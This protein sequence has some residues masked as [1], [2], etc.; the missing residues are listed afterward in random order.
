MGE[1]SDKIGGNLAAFDAVESKLDA[2]L[3]DMGFPGVQETRD[4]DGNTL[5]MPAFMKL[6]SHQ[7]LVERHAQMEAALIA[8]SDP[9]DRCPWG[10]MALDTL[11][12]DGDADGIA[13]VLRFG[14][15][16]TDYGWH[17]A[18]VAVINNDIPTLKSSDQ[19]VVDAIGDTPFLLACRLG[20]IDVLP[21]VSRPACLHA[22]TMIAA[23]CG[24]VDVVGW[25][26]AQGAS[27]DRADPD[28]ATPLLRAVE[29]G[30]FET[31]A[32]LLENGASLDVTVDLMMPRD[33]GD[34]AAGQLQSMIDMMMTQV[35]DM[36]PGAAG[37]Q[38]STIYDAAFDPA[39][40]R[41]LV[42][43]GADPAKFDSD[44]LPAAL[45]IDRPTNR[46]ISRDMFAAQYRVRP[47]RSNPERADVPFWHEQ[48]R[49]GASGHA[50]KV[51]IAG[52][53]AETD[54]PVWS[55]ARYGR[56]ATALPD[57]RI[58]LIGGEH[59]DHYDPDFCIYND[60]TVIGTK[61]EI[62]HYTYPYAAFPPTDFHTATLVEGGIWL[63][64]N[65]GY[66]RGRV[67]GQTQVMW[68][69]TIDFSI[70]KVATTG[71]GPGWISRH[72][73]TLL[74]GAI[75]VMGGQVEPAGTDLKGSYM[76]DLQNRVWHAVN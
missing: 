68:L 14:G 76:L 50:A 52:S 16:A 45:G 60:V 27:A 42:L 41:L 75:C 44:L 28:G 7:P 36:L 15:D 26:I 11:Y 49:S 59:E 18:H 21:H 3:K 65:L 71:Q 5:D 39:I 62:A 48:I 73:A 32:L 72:S 74:D 67:G 1:L 17:A 61:G 23:R 13:L 46:R 58:V 24:A 54:G 4:G 63:I 8:G 43:H 9:N 57:G 38:E 53:N 2:A 35:E 66:E 6:C 69:S 29:A 51:A 34:S 70:H 25:L 33:F 47:G 30:H 22:A 56:T 12:I 64:G 31:V 40:A 19:T 20:R 10:A 37:T 55:F